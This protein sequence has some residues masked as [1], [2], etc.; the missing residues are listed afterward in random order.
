MI[1]LKNFSIV[2]HFIKKRNEF[3]IE[4]KIENFRRKAGN[5]FVYLSYRRIQNERN[6]G[7]LYFQAMPMATDLGVGGQ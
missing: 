6:V 3:G 5:L 4:I 7:L 1:N 2:S